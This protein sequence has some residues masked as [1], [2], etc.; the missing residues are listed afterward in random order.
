ML[1]NFQLSIYAQKQNFLPTLK[2]DKISCSLSHSAA[3]ALRV[4][5]L[6]LITVCMN[7]QEL[8]MRTDDSWTRELFKEL[9]SVEA[10][11][12]HRILLKSP[13]N[14]HGMG[15]MAQ[16]IFFVIIILIP[17]LTKQSRLIASYSKAL[18][19]VLYFSLKIEE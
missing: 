1:I 13:L 9:N 14:I 12:L 4:F 6:K 17:I 5:L 7:I 11:Y 19:F 10:S 2:R 3:S 18:Y 16:S 8:Q 15:S